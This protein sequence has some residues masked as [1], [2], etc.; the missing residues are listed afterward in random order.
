[1]ADSE[2]S[3]YGNTAQCACNHV[4]EVYLGDLQGTIKMEGSVAAVMEPVEPGGLKL[5]IVGYTAHGSAPDLGTITL[6]FD[7]SESIEDSRLAPNSGAEPFPAT[8]TMCLAMVMKA[9]SLP[10]VRLRSRE[11]AV[12]VNENVTSWPPAPGSNY[13]LQSPVVFIDDEGPER[14]SILASE[15]QITSSTFGPDE[16]VVDSG[17]R[18]S[19]SSSDTELAIEGRAARITI[20]LAEAGHVALRTFDANGREVATG[21]GREL[22]PGSHSLEIPADPGADHYRLEVNGEVRS[23]PMPLPAQ[24]S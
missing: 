16:L 3:G 21:I 22:P 14:A 10:G 18:I 4:E 17:L 24:P 1:L 2:V 9:D 11:P 19:L 13:A 15:T 20:R 6:D 8:Q 5:Q 12:L 23:G 7:F